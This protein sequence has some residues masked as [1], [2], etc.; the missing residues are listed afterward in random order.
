VK[1]LVK[2]LLYLLGGFFIIII[3]LIAYVKIALPNVPLE[4]DLKISATPEMIKRGSYLANNVMGCMD[5]HAQRD[6]NYFAGPFIEET[7]GVGGEQFN[8]QM[9]FP[10][11]FT[12]LNL[13]PYHLGDWTDAELFRAITAGV[14][15][16]G[17]ALFPVMPWQSYGRLPKEDIYAVIAYL[18]T[19][20]P[21]EKDYP[22]RELDF[23]L[24]ILI[25]TMPKPGTH[26]LRPDYS[27]TIAHGEY[28]ITAS[29]CN[30]CHTPMDKGN[31]ITELAWSGGTEFPLPT[32]GI[33]RSANLT[34]DDETGIGK[35]SREAFVGRFAAFRDSVF[36]APKVNPGTFNSAMPWTYYA[37]MKD[38][39]LSAIYDYLMS[40][41]PIKNEVVKFTAPE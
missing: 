13:T 12:S 36:T 21:V 9:G 32:G 29:A 38:E 30:D 24:N 27:N 16:D 10:G 19:L 7:R 6:M 40:L 22:P 2:I 1:K 41:E 18:R 31:F 15:K 25:N 8:R 11:A 5:C 20:K 23:P 28:L 35:W 17:R 34:P 33:V 3:G 4:D 26:D 39:D 37:R 14:S